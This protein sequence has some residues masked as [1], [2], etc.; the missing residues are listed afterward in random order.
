[1][2]VVRDSG[3]VQIHGVDDGTRIK[4]DDWRELRYISAAQMKCCPYGIMVRLVRPERSPQ[5]GEVRIK[6]LGKRGG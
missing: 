6:Y 1:M 2:D 3:V 4:V 5:T